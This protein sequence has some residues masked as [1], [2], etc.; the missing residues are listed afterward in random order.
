[1]WIAAQLDPKN[2]LVYFHRGYAYSLKKDAQKLAILDYSR[3]I[4]FNPNYAPAHY[5]RA[6]LYYELGDNDNAL[7]GYTRAIE[8]NPAYADAYRNRALVYR[9]VGL[10][11]L[12]ADD[13]RKYNELKQKQ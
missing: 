6:I 2:A 8:I 11:G 7:K 4:G 3:S 1:M 5:N 12:A 9:R 10:S 13:E